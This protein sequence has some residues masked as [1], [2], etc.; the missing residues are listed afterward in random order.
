MGQKKE[1]RR[2]PKTSNK[3]IRYVVLRVA[4]VR[5]GRKLKARLR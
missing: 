3:E 4:A 5:K 2:Q 1:L